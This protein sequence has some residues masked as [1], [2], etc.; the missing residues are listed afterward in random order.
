MITERLKLYLVVCIGLMATPF[1]GASVATGS[2]FWIGVA[3][4]VGGFLLLLFGPTEYVWTLLVLGVVA[5]FRPNFLKFNI[6]FAELGTVIL[7]L[8]LIVKRS[9]LQRKALQI[10]PLL[11]WTPIMIIVGIIFLHTLKGGDLGFKILGGGAY[12]ARKH[13]PFFLAVMSY[14]I[15]INSVSRGKASLRHLPLLYVIFVFIGSLPGLITTFIPA[16]T[17]LAY[18]LTG[19][20]NIEGYREAIS[21]RGVQLERIGAFGG[22]GI[23]LQLYLVSWYSIKNWW[24]PE[25]WWVATLSALA[26]FLCMRS[27]FR[28]ALLGYVFVTAIACLIALKWRSVVVALLA[29]VLC[30]FLALGNN[31]LF[32]LPV[33]AQ[34]ALSI[35]PGDWDPDAVYSAEASSDF[36]RTIQQI[37]LKSY[38]RP[39]SLIGSGFKY[40]PNEAAKYEGPAGTLPPAETYRGFVIRK[41]FHIGWISLFDSVGIIGSLA[42]IWFTINILRRMFSWIKRNGLSAL[43]VPQ[44]WLIIIYGQTIIPFWTVFGDLSNVIVMLCIIAGLT[45]VLFP[46]R[47]AVPQVEPQEKLTPQVPSPQMA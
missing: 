25:R 40:N 13:L 19:T 2:F 8:N 11:F 34:R 6:S 29:A 5:D 10:G 15:V 22:I 45:H 32:H 47:A 44:R 9:I 26:L 28:S 42:F 30:F 27:G 37:Y 7:F 31:N 41:E 3:I 35:L 23:A 46:K 20:A 4:A 38:F 21:L 17:P 43:S 12:G 16:L 1:L 39:W 24:R 18:F 14:L 36:R 33:A